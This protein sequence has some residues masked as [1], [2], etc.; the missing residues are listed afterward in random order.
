MPA[1]IELHTTRVSLDEIKQDLSTYLQRAQAG[2]IFVV[3]KAGKPV[4]EIRP[5]ATA[6][7]YLRPFGLAAGQFIVP[8]DFDA[9]LPEQIMREFEES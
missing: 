5:V 7:Q 8:D 2:E 1:T 9:P 3:T 6:S 4:A